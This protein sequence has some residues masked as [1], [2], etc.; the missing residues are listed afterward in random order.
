M[1]LLEESIDRSKKSGKKLTSIKGTILIYN[2][3]NNLRF[4]IIFVILVVVV[5]FCVMKVY[6]FFLF[7]LDEL[8][9]CLNVFLSDLMQFDKTIFKYY[10]KIHT[11][12]NYDILIIPTK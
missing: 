12:I 2:K 6:S 4:K 11:N 9:K 8:A 3:K 1:V 5:R 7:I 10:Y